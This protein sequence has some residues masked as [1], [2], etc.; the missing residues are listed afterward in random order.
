MA[1][2]RKSGAILLLPNSSHK[3]AAEDSEAVVHQPQDRGIRERQR[4]PDRLLLCVHIVIAITQ[5][6]FGD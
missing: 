6:S 3:V 4:L 2:P 5:E 1:V